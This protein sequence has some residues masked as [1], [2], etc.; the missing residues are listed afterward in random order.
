MDKFCVVGGSFTSSRTTS[1]A[2]VSD[3]N[4]T[5]KHNK[6]MKCTGANIPVLMDGSNTTVAGV[7]VSHNVFEWF[8]TNSTASFRPSGDSDSFNVSHLVSHHNTWAGSWLYGRGNILYDE[9][10]GATIRTHKLHSFVGNIHVQINTKG[11]WF[12]GADGNGSPDPTNAPLHVGNWAYL[13]GVGCRGEFSQNIDASSGGLGTMFAQAYAG[14]G[15]SIGTG[16]TYATRNDAKF[17]SPQHTT[18]NGSSATAGAG[19]GDYTL[20]SGSNCAGMVTSAMAKVAR[21]DLAGQTRSA[22]ASATGAYKGASE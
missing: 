5:V 10:P 21:F 15:A 8:S 19:N 13:Y 2:A 17:T 14:L 12:L 1:G 18:W 11:D 22:T 3:S 9:K 7:D 20:Q 4:S 16:A 6:F